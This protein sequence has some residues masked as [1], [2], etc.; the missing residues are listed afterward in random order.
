MLVDRRPGRSED[1]NV[2]AAHFGDDRP[3]LAVGKPLDLAGI[4]LLPTAEA[5]GFRRV[6]LAVSPGA[7]SRLRCR[8]RTTDE[9]RCRDGVAVFGPNHSVGALGGQALANPYQRTTPRR[10]PT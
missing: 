2:V 10:V 7:S 3:Q 5:G 8:E 9:C 6:S 4:D 1:E